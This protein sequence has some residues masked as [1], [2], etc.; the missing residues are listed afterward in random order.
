MSDNEEES[1]S[2]SRRALTSLAVVLLLVAVATGVGALLDL[3]THD[4]S[5]GFALASLAASLMLALAAT[6]ALRQN[7]ELIR[8]TAKEA[9]ASRTIAEEMRRDRE[10][11]F[12]PALT[13]AFAYEFDTAP[14]ASG[15]YRLPQCRGSLSRT[16][17]RARLSISASVADVL[18]ATRPP[19]PGSPSSG[20]VS[21]PMTSG[22]S[23]VSS[24]QGAIRLRCKMRNGSGVSLTISCKPEMS[25]SP[26]SD[27]TTGLANT[28]DP[29]VVRSSLPRSNGTASSG[30]S[31][32]RTG[33][34]ARVGIGACSGVPVPA[35]SDWRVRVGG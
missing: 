31:I 30:C 24:A 27:T 10:L 3:S 6:L 11:A 34:A 9:E 28:T 5:A 32:N 23:P 21:P 15:G 4:D 16:S 25:W 35:R 8:A 33:C 7:V 29:R 20:K 12:K 14:N 17:A 26:L 18:P 1:G 2:L 22:G 13:V 19:I